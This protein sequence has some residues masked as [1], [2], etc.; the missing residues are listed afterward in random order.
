MKKPI[1][2][3]I[4]GHTETVSQLE[5][6]EIVEAGDW[7]VSMGHMRADWYRAE[8]GMKLREFHLPHVRPVVAKLQ[9]AASI[10]R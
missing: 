1:A 8:P 7:Y 3:E 2:V 10:V 9:Y 5:V 6:G 4:N